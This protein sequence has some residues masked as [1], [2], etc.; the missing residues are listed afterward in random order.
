MEKELI[1][2]KNRA[3]GEGA[4]RILNSEPSLNQNPKRKRKK[5]QLVAVIH[6]VQNVQNTEIH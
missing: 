4:N 1:F 2:N 5:D 6:N 3:S